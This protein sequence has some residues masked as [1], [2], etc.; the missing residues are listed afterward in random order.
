ME[1][2]WGWSM[3]GISKTLPWMKEAAEQIWLCRYGA[4]RRD[5]MVARPTDAQDSDLEWEEE[6]YDDSTVA[7]CKMNNPSGSGDTGGNH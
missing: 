3:R 1:A 7:W 2:R 4:R 6:D 5:A